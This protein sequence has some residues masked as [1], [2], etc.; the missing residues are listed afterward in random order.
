[1]N[2]AAKEGRGIDLDDARDAGTV[3]ETADFLLAL[4]R[5]DDAI[6][7][8]LVDNRQ[9]SWKV[10]CKLLKSR[11]GGKGQQFTL[12]M[13]QLSLVI[14]DDKGRAANRAREHNHFASRGKSWDELRATET[15]PRQMRLRADLA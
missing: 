9:S 14:V 6:Q 2:R 1:V 12:Q 7:E 4:H 3:E 15:A 5:P 10:M 8:G 13:D 11:H